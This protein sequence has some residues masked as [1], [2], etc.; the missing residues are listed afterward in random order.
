LRVLAQ[1]CNRVFTSLAD[2]LAVRLL[3]HLHDLNLS[4]RDPLMQQGRNS[5]VVNGPVVLLLEELQSASK[6]A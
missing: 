3:C 2:R 5:V 4:P 6:V 1:P